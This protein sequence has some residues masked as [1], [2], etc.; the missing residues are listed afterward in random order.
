MRAGSITA[1]PRARP[2]ADAPVGALVDGADEVAKAW[3]LE[4]LAAAPLA[5]AGG[6][7]VE[8][9]AAEGPELC[10]AVARALADDD[11]LARFAAGGDLFGAAGRVGELAGAPDAGSA[12]AAVEALR[13][14]VWESALGALSRPSAALVADLADRLGAVCAAITAAVLAPPAGDPV[15]APAP[16]PAPE[17]PLQQTIRESIS[18]SG[19]DRP[20]DLARAAAGEAVQASALR[21]EPPIMRP[22]LDSDPIAPDATPRVT[23]GDPRT[24]L[25]ARSAEFLAD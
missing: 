5:A 6:V 9:L 18:A 12:F 4:L 22:P 16:G 10:T 17:R 2:V 13:R 11:E 8:H 15:I 1:P 3:L 19:M 20:A 25:A 21:A 23:D 14:A 7:R 24:H